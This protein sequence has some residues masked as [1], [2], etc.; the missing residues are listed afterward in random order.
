MTAFVCAVGARAECPYDWLPGEGVPG[1]DGAVDAAVPF[2]DGTGPALYVGGWFIVA[3]SAVA[4]GVAKWNPVT[5]TWSALGSGVNNGVS[6]LAVL[7]GKLYAGGDFSTADGQSANSIASWDPPTQTWSALGLGTD[8][9]VGAL[10]V[11]DGKLYAGGGF[12]TAG[13]VSANRIACW[14]PPTQTWSA[15]GSGIGG[16]VGA[17]AVLDGKLYAGGGFTAAGG[18]SASYIACWD[19]AAQTWSGLGEGVNGDDHPRVYALAALNGKLYAGG[20]FTTAGGVDAHDI[21]CWDPAAQSW[22]ALG[23]GM[24]EDSWFGKSSPAC[25]GRRR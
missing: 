13:G 14:D 10:A 4:D 6:A 25:N 5:Q 18:M 17:L 3:G 2:D 22:S 11:L 16:W 19:P 20:R 12:T 1:T 9:W 24:G 21:A 15:L 7:D 8:G 23:P